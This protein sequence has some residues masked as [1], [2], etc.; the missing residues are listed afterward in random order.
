MKTP[1]LDEYLATLRDKIRNNPYE[2]RTKFRN[3]DA[4]HG[5][6][7][8]SREALAHII[9]SLLGPT[10]PLSHTNYLKIL[11]RLGLKDKPVIRHDEFLSAFQEKMSVSSSADQPDW[12]D[13]IR[14]SR[15]SFNNPVTRKAT[16]V[17]VILKEKAKLK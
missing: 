13:P 4:D 10:K 16:Q 17:I 7:G 14:S 11:D 9:A 5:S 2:I 12:L 8:I 1:S 6:K 3:V 15:N